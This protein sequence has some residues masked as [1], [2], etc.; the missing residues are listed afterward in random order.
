VPTGPDVV[1]RLRDHGPAW[2]DGF[3]N[4]LAPAVLEE[5]VYRQALLMLLA[6]ALG[7]GGAAVVS[8]LAFGL[9]HLYFG[10]QAVASKCVMGA[11]FAAMVLSGFGLLSVMLGHCVLNAAVYALRTGL[12]KRL[13]GARLKGARA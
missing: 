12:L 1:W 4:L 7:L 6:P 5:L 3:V 10:V 8:T 2:R 9:V 13:P 11:L